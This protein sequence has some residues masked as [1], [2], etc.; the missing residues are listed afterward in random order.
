MT[1]RKLYK[2]DRIGNTRVWWMEYDDE[3]YRTCSGI[4]NGAIVESGW[5]YPNQKNVGKSNETTIKEQ[6]LSEVESQYDYQLVQG[7]YHE[8]IDTIDNGASY[9]ECQL[10]EK[11]NPEKMNNFPY[12]VQP[13]FNGCVSGESFVYTEN[14]YTKVK[15]VYKNKDRYILSFNN[16]SK[17]TEMKEILFKGKE[18]DDISHKNKYN[19]KRIKTKSGKILVITDNHKVYLPELDVWRDVSELK[20]GDKLLAK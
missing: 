10:A 9:V 15:D 6:V 19:W 16:Q 17:K 18:I 4:L 1:V 13:K 14:G 11:Y 12:I 3:K 7:K 2:K 5:V 8:S 20:V